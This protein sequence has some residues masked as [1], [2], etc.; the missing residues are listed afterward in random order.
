MNHRCCETEVDYRRATRSKTIT[1]PLDC[2]NVAH[3]QASRSAHAVYGEA[4]N[5][6]LFIGVMAFFMGAGC[7]GA[8][9]LIFG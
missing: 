3:Y 6:W 8:A 1:D 9:W 2:G 5:H 4:P 7:V